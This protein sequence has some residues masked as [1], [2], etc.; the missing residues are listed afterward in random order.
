MLTSIIISVGLCLLFAL[1]M[2]VMLWYFSRS[3]PM[4]SFAHPSA[5]THRLSS[6]SPGK[7]AA[8]GLE[9]DDEK[10]KL[11]ILFVTAHPDDECMFFSPTILSIR[12]QIDLWM[13]KRRR[14]IL[15][16]LNPS[17]TP[18]GRA[19]RKRRPKGTTG[20]EGEELE[21]FSQYN[22]L[23]TAAHQMYIICLS[24]GNHDGLGED[25]KMELICS[26]T[27]MGFLEERITILD[28]L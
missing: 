26:C 18:S 5:K 9:E 13:E 28:V 20:F 8:L 3:A 16:P 19:S 10:I 11:P 22:W 27:Q 15:V 24:S 14:N 2:I 25:R 1:L 12:R 21:D 23:S 4:Y 7:K 6:A 17:S